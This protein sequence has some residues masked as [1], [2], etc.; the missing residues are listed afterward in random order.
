MH[1]EKGMG[2]EFTR[3]TQ[4]HRELLEKFLGLLTENP[5]ALPDLM[6]EPEG[7][8]TVEMVSDRAPA[9][10]KTEDPLLG[11]FR[12]QPSLPAESFLA[13]LRKQRGLVT[14]A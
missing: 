3:S 14:T 13:E 10:A 9:P 11:L 6:V 1:S 7:L 12:N 5:A 8:E 4:E 2:V